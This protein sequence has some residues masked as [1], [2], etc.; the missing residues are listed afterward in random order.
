MGSGMNP[1]CHRSS[2]VPEEVFHENTASRSITSCGWF[3]PKST[4]YG[5]SVS[6]PVKLAGAN[7]L[8]AVAELVC[9][10][11]DRDRAGRIDH[12]PH[13]HVGN[14]LWST[15]IPGVVRD[16][17]HHRCAYFAASALQYSEGV[18]IASHRRVIDVG[19]ILARMRGE[20]IL[21]HIDHPSMLRLAIHQ[22]SPVAVHVAVI[23]VDV[24]VL[25]GQGLVERIVRRIDGERPQSDGRRREVLVREEV[26]QRLVG[27]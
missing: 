20:W 2:C 12:R 9:I 6:V 4:M 16:R 24:P 3:A 23:P 13:K 22:R 25:V 11:S 27:D 5:A 19:S 17:P 7:P 10:E 8:S 18:V 14:P 21:P 15:H 1:G 26:P